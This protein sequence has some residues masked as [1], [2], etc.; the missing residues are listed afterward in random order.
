MLGYLGAILIV[1]AVTHLVT[2]LALACW[3]DAGPRCAPVIAGC[4]AAGGCAVVA[5]L[6]PGRLGTAAMAAVVVVL[7]AGL[8]A[9]MS[10]WLHPVGAAVW[11]SWLLFGAALLGWAGWRSAR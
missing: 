9:R 5:R 6:M 8:Y 10:R 3:P 2:V 11:S 1:F 4:A 7:A